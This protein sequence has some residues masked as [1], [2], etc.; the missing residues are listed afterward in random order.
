MYFLDSTID[1][2]KYS[3]REKPRRIVMAMIVNHELDFTKVRF[4]Q[5]DSVV[6]IFVIL[7]SSISTGIWTPD[8]LNL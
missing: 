3:V 5:L 4:H 1:L 2:N 7:E 6:D 8:V